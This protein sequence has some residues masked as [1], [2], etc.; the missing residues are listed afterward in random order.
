[1]RFGGV[2]RSERYRVAWNG[3]AF[4]EISGADLIANGYRIGPIS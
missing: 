2:N 3:G 4:R 1:V